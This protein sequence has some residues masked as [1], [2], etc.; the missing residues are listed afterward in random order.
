MALPHT[1]RGNRSH[2]SLRRHLDAHTAR[3]GPDLR[4]SGL[5]ARALASGAHPRAAPKARE[6]TWEARLTHFWPIR[7][8]YSVLTPRTLRP[9]SLAPPPR[10]LQASL[11]VGGKIVNSSAGAL[12]GPEN[13][14]SNPVVT[15]YRAL[16]WLLCGLDQLRLRPSLQSLQAGSGR[17]G[18]P[19][20]S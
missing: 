1:P 20:G 14:P 6:A 15:D 11:A 8:S 3:H 4:G 12:R 16:D 9:P 13:L 17:L 19:S 10:A 5:P 18:S 2:L 7:L